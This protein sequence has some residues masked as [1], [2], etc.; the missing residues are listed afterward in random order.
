M[1]DKFDIR[2]RPVQWQADVGEI[3]SAFHAGGEHLANRSYRAICEARKLV[4]WQASAL[5]EDVK[6]VMKDCDDFAKAFAE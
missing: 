1:Q 5:S 2:K 6:R 3:V 4:L